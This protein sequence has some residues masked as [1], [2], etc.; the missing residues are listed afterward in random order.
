MINPCIEIT[1]IDRVRRALS[2]LLDVVQSTVGAYN[3]GADI[4][5]HIYLLEWHL[6]RAVDAQAEAEF[7]ND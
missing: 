3:A 1:E 5:E 7:F 6:E 4:S 2:T